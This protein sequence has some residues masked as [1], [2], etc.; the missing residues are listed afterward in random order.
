MN[1]QA[2]FAAL[3]DRNIARLYRFFY[4]RT[5][6]HSVA[7]DLTSETF[8]R[9]ADSQSGSVPKKPDAF[10]IGIA[11]NVF[12]GYLQKKYKQEITIED[13]DLAIETSLKQETVTKP[14]PIEQLIPLLEKLPSQQSLIIRLRLVEK[15]SL[16]EICSHLNKQM[17][18]VKTTQNRAIKSL[19]KLIAVGK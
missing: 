1:N 9:F 7:E 13:M 14:D 10:L 19:R 11:R 18:Y 16:A 17:S 15:L 3:Y 4:S 6:N 8:L 2:E 12:I 5:L